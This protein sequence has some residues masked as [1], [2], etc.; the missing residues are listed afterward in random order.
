MR[1][2]RSLVTERVTCRACGTHILPITAEKTGGLC[3]P[4]KGN[5]R[6]SI[7]DS[8]RRLEEDKKYRAS[9]PW[10]HW[11]SLVKR[12]HE[13]GAGFDGLS[14][15]EQ[16]FFATRVLIGDVYNG[17]FHQYFS[18]SSGDYYSRASEMLIEIGAQSTLRLLRE[19]KALLFGERPVPANQ[20]ERNVAL[21]RIEQNQAEM[22]KL[23]RVDAAFWKD[24]DSLSDK[25]ETYAEANDLRKDF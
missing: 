14:P 7:E 17:G 2:V 19:A 8:R 25:L 1:D 4:C 6:Q 21:S 3:M 16:K 24:P 9:P 23:E 11:L 20:A 18:N 10:K 5:Y 22:D 12:V 15:E 13:S